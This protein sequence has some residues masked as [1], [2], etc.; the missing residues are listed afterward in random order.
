MHKLLG[1][2]VHEWGD[3]WL[4]SLIP[5]S[6]V[7]SCSFAYVGWAVIGEQMSNRKS[8][9]RGEKWNKVIML[10][11]GMGSS[12]PLKIGRYR[13]WMD[14]GCVQVY[15]H[16]RNARMVVK[17]ENDNL[18]FWCILVAVCNR[19]NTEWKNWA[20]VSNDNV[21]EI[22]VWQTWEKAASLNELLV[23]CF[24][25][26]L[27]SLHFIDT[28]LLT[29]WSCIKTIIHPPCLLVLHISETGE[30]L[31]KKEVQR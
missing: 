15:L 29:P 30:M 4:L 11:A 27:H 28:N 18:W 6:T 5:R 24:F 26:L 25:F 3:G 12:R 13:E 7:W 10:T 14:D 17:T 23:D 16:F 8:F 9:T 20:S 31:P 2:T 21:Y 19:S 22:L 1:D